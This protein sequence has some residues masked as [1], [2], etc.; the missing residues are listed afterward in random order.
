MLQS[1]APGSWEGCTDLALPRCALAHDSATPT[2]VPVCFVAIPRAPRQQPVCDA[3]GSD[4]VAG[5]RNTP[6]RDTRCMA[7][8][9]RSEPEL[10]TRYVR[11]MELMR[12]PQGCGVEEA[13][14]A[15]GVTRGGCRGMIRDLKLLLPVETVYEQHGGR[16]RGRRA[17]HFVRLADDGALKSD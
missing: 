12:R 7:W 1:F 3:F 16:G 4:R 10:S 13:S 14:R 9:A 2:S 8:P 5:L 11:L 17:V 6:C 15:L